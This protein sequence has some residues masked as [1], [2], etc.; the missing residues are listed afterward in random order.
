MSTKFPPF[1]GPEPPAAPSRPT[2]VDA[3]ALPFPLPPAAADAG[4][5]PF[6]LPPAANQGSTAYGPGYGGY[7]NA[8]LG[9]SEISFVHYLQMLYRRRYIALAT[10]VSIVAGVAFYTF[11]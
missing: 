6:P 3:G 2:A 1:D 11:T 7:G 8:A 9:E 4:P 5:L 10:F